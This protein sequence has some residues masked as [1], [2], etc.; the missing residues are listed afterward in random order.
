MDS[1]AGN[2]PVDD[3]DVQRAFAEAARFFVATVERVPADQWDRPGL[4]QWSVRDLAGHTSR[5]LIT[6][7]TYLGQPADS[8]AA[9]SAV[10]YF[11]AARGSFGDPE[12]I[13]RRGREAGA[14]LG[15][16]P[17]AAIRELAERVV[18]L[19]AGADL[20]RLLT[21]P[22]GGMR[23]RDYLATRIFEL[24]VHTLDLAAAIGLPLEPPAESAAISLEIAAGLALRSGQAGD[25][26]L[27]LTG[28]RPLPPGFSVL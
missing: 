26:L 11:I 20:D 3:A 16:N 2:A 8:V 24:V 4:G 22:A 1:G 23:L 13:A 15:P 5:A 10:D 19:V 6:L 12:P 17:A 21:T 7:E 27:G 28:R 18:P 25:L 14:A 9:G